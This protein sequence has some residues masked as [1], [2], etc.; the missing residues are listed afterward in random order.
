MP[1]II[2][3]RNIYKRYRNKVALDGVSVDVEPGRIFGLLGPNG[4][5]KT[6]L[7]R[8]MTR[9][10]TQDSGHIDFKGEPLAP[11]H[12][13][14]VGYLPE[15]RGLYRKMKVGEQCLYLARLKGLEKKDAKERVEQWLERF[16]LTDQWDR[17]VEELSKG[18]AQKLQF[19]I[20][21]IHE[22]ELLILDE[23]LSG[24]DPINAERVKE[25]VLAMRDRGVSI[26][27]STHNMSSVEEI[28][29]RIALIN[30]GR[31]VLS[32][33]L[34]DIK[35]RYSEKVYDV[36]FKGELIGFTNALWTN[37]ELLYKE[38]D[39]D[40]FRARVRILRENRLNQL[41]QAIVPVVEVEEVREVIP[42][43]Q[44]IFIKAVGGKD[45]ETSDA[46]DPVSR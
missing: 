44:D 19:I 24:F 37:F 9:I 17:K 20:T 4:A 15:E 25:E 33:E 43:M 38:Q 12:I 1:P 6:T 40:R 32:G 31:V 13:P 27:L 18:M 11:E 8:I 34:K 30:D 14:R 5:G 22:P 36:F 35:E 45:P 46:D 16:E 3:A 39:G 26:V 28:C 42:S 2:S 21:V 41:L 29:E 10:N 23:P 7:I